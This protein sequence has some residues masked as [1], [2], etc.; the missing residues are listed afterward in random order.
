MSNWICPID[1]HEIANGQRCDV[2]EECPDSCSRK[3]AGLA[4]ASIFA[5]AEGEATNG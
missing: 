3:R 2:T 1:N 5:K 4:L